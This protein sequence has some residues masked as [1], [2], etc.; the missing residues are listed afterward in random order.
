MKLE[1]FVPTWLTNWGLT[2]HVVYGKAIA[3]GMFWGSLRP[4]NI[5]MDTGSFSSRICRWFSTISNGWQLQNYQ[6]LSQF[7]ETPTLWS[8][9]LW[10]SS[11]FLGSEPA[12]LTRK[13]D[14]NYTM[15]LKSRGQRSRSITFQAKTVGCFIVP[16][17]VLLVSKTHTKMRYIGRFNVTKNN[18][19]LA[20]AFWR[21]CV[22]QLAWLVSDK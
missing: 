16:C 20:S 7:W 15:A 2:L 12:S 17:T 19:T 13:Y 6:R 9:G 21:I 14:L 1:L 5:D 22:C 4:S 18:C 8:L 3:L 10:I 11:H